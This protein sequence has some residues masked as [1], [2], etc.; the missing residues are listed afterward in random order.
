MAAKRPAATENLAVRHRACT[1]SLP[2]IS[3]QPFPFG[4]IIK[5]SRS[6]PFFL[7]NADSKPYD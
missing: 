4:T 2:E 1:V 5:V 3:G 7:D 6:H